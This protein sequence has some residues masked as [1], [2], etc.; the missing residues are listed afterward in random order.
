MARRKREP[1]PFDPAVF[2]DPVALQTRR[3]AATDSAP[4][5]RQA[6]RV[7]EAAP[8]GHADAYRLVF[9]NAS[10]GAWA[11]GRRLLE[12]VFLGVILFVVVNHERGPV[13][14]VVYGIGLV[15]WT[16]QQFRTHLHYVFDKARGVYWRGPAE[17][18]PATEVRP[19]AGRGRGGG[20]RPPTGPR[21]GRR[22]RAG[23]APA[24][25]RRSTRCETRAGPRPRGRS[26]RLSGRD[27]PA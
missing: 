27:G 11:T 26:A 10:S 4:R 13:L 16:F 7:P 12:G 19:P 3:D 1:A 22:P 20:P 24:P 8:G 9:R 17:P 14:S 25:T 23:G 15:S 18:R 21:R 6:H 5:D 2:E